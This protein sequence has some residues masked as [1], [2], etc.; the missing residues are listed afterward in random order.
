MDAAAPPSPENPRPPSQSPK[1]LTRSRADR[2]LGGVC[3]GLGRYLGIDAV[4]VR[5]AAVVLLFVGGAGAIAYLAMLLLVP[6]AEAGTEPE[7]APFRRDLSGMAIAAIVV[8][9]IV[10]GPFLLGGGFLLAGLLVPLGIVA[11]IG[12]AAW[13][14]V[15]GEPVTGDARDLVR[16]SALGVAV[17]VGCG[18][19]FVAG[20]WVTGIAG[21]VVAGSTVIAAGVVLVVGAF[22]GRVR[23][24][25]LPAIALAL[26]AGLV[27]AAG[28][29]LDGGV[30][31]RDYA[32]SSSGAIK[33][34]YELGAGQLIVDLRKAGLKPGD[35]RL[36]L[37]VGMGQAV[38]IVP[39]DVCVASTADVGAGNVDVFG[40]SNAGIDVRW[41]D[42]QAAR[43]AQPRVLVD[44]ELG[45]GELLVRHDRADIDPGRGRGRD[46]GGSN[47]HRPYRGAGNTGCAGA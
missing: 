2:V 36:K 40:R 18:L 42:G 1:R 38:L 30:G 19:L 13:W 15:S 32:P 26:G 3:G 46:P 35:T 47:G 16:R 45:L 34:R 28:I 23:W 4:V 21:G 12:L 33:D 43:L 5:V 11:L 8:G 24:V 14:L 20:F 31:E 25:A 29:K 44:A 37:Q 17:L 10:L 6:D 39:E 7:A 41:D 9:L 27:A 22:S